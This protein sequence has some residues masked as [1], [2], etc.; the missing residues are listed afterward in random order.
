[1]LAPGTIPVQF[2]EAAAR[3]QNRVAFQ[4]KRDGRYVQLSYGEV[5]DQAHRLA[6]FL[7]QLQVA[8]GDR[9]ALLS[10]NRPEWC[11]AYL[12]IV[13]AGATAVPLDVQMEEEELET[14]LH[15][16]ES[17]VIVASEAELTRIESLIRT[18]PVRPEI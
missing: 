12:G 11:V 15:H 5:A 10:E 17:R 4:I 8:P 18:L 2:F 16:S 7:V 3:F 14:L 6:A 13:A 9:I 1:M